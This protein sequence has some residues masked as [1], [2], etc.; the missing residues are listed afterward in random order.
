MSVRKRSNQPYQIKGVDALF[1]ETEQTETDNR[2]ISTSDIVL[3]KQQPRRYFDPEKLNQLTES[4]KQHGILEPLLVRLGAQG[5]YELIAGERRYKAATTLGLTEVPVV[6]RDFNDQEALQVAL[7][8]NLQ[9]EDLN[10]IEETEGILELAAIRL[11]QNTEYVIALLHQAAHPERNSVDNVIHTEEWKVLQEVFGVVGRFTP[12]SFRTN[13]LPL[14]NLPI[15]VLNALREGRIAYTKA[16]AIAQVKDEVQRS[17]LLKA[18]IQEDLS[19]TQIKE[20]VVAIKAKANKDVDPVP[21]LKTRFESV[22]RC[23][24]KSKIWDN[25]TKQ[26]TLEKLLE[27]LENLVNEE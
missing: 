20:R 12:E 3:S 11:Q 10:P 16:R 1:G 4:I 27:T 18:A 8:E 19:L 6:I 15:N 14:L 25:P 26:K 7:I 5:K 23:V 13:R 17:E 24:K 2:Y 9:R 21:S 22:Y